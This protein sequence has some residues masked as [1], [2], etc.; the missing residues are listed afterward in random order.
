MEILRHPK[1][2]NENEETDYYVYFS[3]TATA[4]AYV[5][6]EDAIEARDLAWDLENDGSLDWEINS[7][8]AEIDD[9]EEY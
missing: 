3:T 4:T 5:T 1:P 7:D 6:A 2:I 8:N 9:I